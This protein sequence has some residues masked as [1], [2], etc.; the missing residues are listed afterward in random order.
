MSI[1]D[2]VP[3][4]IPEKDTDSETEYHEIDITSTNSNDSNDSDAEQDNDIEESSEIEESI[5]YDSFEQITRVTSQP[6]TAERSNMFYSNKNDYHL[7]KSTE[8]KYMSE[9][10]AH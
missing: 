8:Y 5:Y 2:R 9:P 6:I 7:I 4:T 3:V 1:E 10:P